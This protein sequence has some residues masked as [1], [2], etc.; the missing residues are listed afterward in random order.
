METTKFNTLNVHHSHSH[1]S[2]R[3]VIARIVKNLSGGL[4]PK[5]GAKYLNNLGEFDIQI[6]DVNG[7]IDGHC[8]QMYEKN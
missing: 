5:D 6:T 4:T 1:I 3:S 8:V 2:S 7:V